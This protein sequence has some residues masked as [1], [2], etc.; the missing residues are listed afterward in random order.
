MTLA[1]T[2]ERAIP[3]K[4]VVGADV[5]LPHLQRYAFAA[6]YC[7]QKDVV[8]LACGSGYG[9]Y[10]LS[11][12]AKSVQGVDID[13]HAIE[14]AF[15]T[16]KAANLRYGLDDITLGFPRGEVYTAF[17][18][19]EHLENPSQVLDLIPN[20]ATLIYSVPVEDGSRYHMRAYTREDIEQTFG[21]FIFYQDA[22][23]MIVPKQMAWFEPKY[24]IGVKA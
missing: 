19:L 22:G 1:Y 13:T 9:S 20:G 21:G 3:W 23:G 8:D 16:F 5:M 7:W 6:K 11:M 18:C 24:V 2:G 14:Y 12:V 17:E 15:T 10:L 4:S